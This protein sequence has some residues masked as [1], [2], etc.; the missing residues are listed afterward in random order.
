MFVRIN[1]EMK[2]INILLYILGSLLYLAMP[3]LLSP[4]FGNKSMFEVRP[5]QV[6]FAQSVLFL[7]FFFFN[8]FYAVPKLLYNHKRMQF[9]LWALAFLFITVVLPIGLQELFK[10]HHPPALHGVHVHRGPGPLMFIDKSLFSYSAVLLVSILLGLQRRYLRLKQEKLATEISY[11]KAQIN[12][13]FLFNALNNIYALSLSQSEETPES[14]MR[15]SRM[16]RYVVSESAHEWVPLEKELQY[17]QDY[18]DF[19]KLRMSDSCT[20]NF[21]VHGD[22]GNKVISPLVLIPFV[23]NAFKYGIN[24]D[25]KSRIELEIKVDEKSVQA[26]IQ[27]TMVVHDVLPEEKSEIGLQNTK[28]RLDFVYGNSYQLEIQKI[29]DLY[30][31]FISIPLK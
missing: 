14:I 9:V 28:K 29:N 18:V 25:K 4:D 27:N 3:T 8:H 26:H 17:I 20:L 6:H 2:R 22:S 16:M 7:G 13:H 5:F 11:L 19:Q 31:V 1:W 24:P 10:P 30:D 15:L 12:P 23:E 21:S